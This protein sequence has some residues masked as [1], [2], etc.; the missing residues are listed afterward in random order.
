MPDVAQVLLL[1]GVLLLIHSLVQPLAAR[2]RLP[3]TVL[4]AAI[5][6]GLG[7]L[8][9]LGEAP[10]GEM[11]DMGPLTQLARLVAEFE[12][13]SQTI[14]TIFLPILL[15]QTGL[16][17]DVRRML[18]DIAPVLVM[19]VVAVVGCTLTV[20]VALWGVS[21]EALVVCLLLGAIIATTDPVAVVGIF[22]EVGAPRR[23]SILIEGESVFNDAAAIALFV[24]FLAALVTGRDLSWS[25]AIWLFLKGFL[26]G[27]LLGLA[28]ARLLVVAMAPLRRQP[29]AETSMTLALAYLVFVA[30]EHYLGVSGVVAVVTAALVIASTGRARLTPDSWAQLE[31]VW[32]QLGFWASSLIFIFASMLIPR[33]LSESLDW[34]DGLY[35]AVLVLAA[36]AAR[37]VMIFG[38]L[39]VLSACGL[40]ERVSNAYKAVIFWGGLRG[41]VTLALALGVTESLFLSDQ[42][43]SF[44]A[45]QATGFVLFTLLVNAT[46][47]RWL[48]GALRLDR[49]SGVDRALRNRTISLALS[50]ILERVDETAES[51]GIARPVAMPVLEG[52][53]ARL[54]EA[55]SDDTEMPLSAAEQLRL[56]LIVLTNREEELYLQHFGART[57]SRRTAVG[58][59]AKAGR[60]RDGAKT[61]GRIGYLKAARDSGRFQLW[62]RLASQLHRRFGIDHLLAVRLA[63]RFET[64]LISRMVLNE[65]VLFNAAKLEPMLGPVV[66][67]D[68]K[69]MLAQRLETCEQALDALRLQ[70]PDY[71]RRLEEQF[72][73]R[74]ALRLEEQEYVTLLR[75]SV[76]SPDIFQDLGR[77]LHADAVKLRVR[78]KLDM[79]LSTE[80]L[81]RR[82]PMFDQLSEPELRELCDLL[83]P[84]FAHPEERLFTAGDRGDELFFIASGAVEVRQKNWVVRL[85]RG[86]F[87]GE[88]AVLLGRRRSA[89]VTAIAY[90]HLLVLPG[91]D[92][93]RFLRNHP[94]LRARIR[95]VAEA[96]RIAAIRYPGRLVSAVT[97][98]DGSDASAALR[99][100]DGDAG[101][102]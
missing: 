91:R 41:A 28:A 15:F 25:E 97:R 21:E 66:T 7:T 54:E 70:Y 86:D 38:V 8:A 69:S 98:D 17:I 78:P 92:F 20:G 60:L 19:A 24:V 79:D 9:L 42:V 30:G 37:A 90:C 36:H 63:D 50:N 74:A 59:L 84:R 10:A 101:P 6:V 40:A 87:F 82:F 48:I 100:R 27:A 22:R 51:H 34:A 35:L 99:G 76:I 23:L 3:S 5:G 26:G 1:V 71:E 102:D 88:M 81:V 13:S 14:L 11:P 29:L 2:L 85:G 68:L 57:V 67:G 55:R 77:R 45:A 58:L 47:L 53:R 73:R 65:L 16:T 33:F 75:E 12:I 18:D 46:T 94:Q 80:A 72:L 89:T 31:G 62:F 4:L 93:R 44:V 95:E 56:G 61:A 43:K 49:L 64:L 39:P 52:Y 96:R 83:K 32:N